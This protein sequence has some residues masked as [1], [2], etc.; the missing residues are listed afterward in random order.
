MVFWEQLRPTYQRMIVK[1]PARLRTSFL[2]RL[3]CGA[4]ELFSEHE[5][6]GCAQQEHG[7]ALK[8]DVLLSLEWQLHGTKLNSGGNPAGL[9]RSDS[10]WRRGVISETA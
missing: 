8:T 6:L 7:V 2:L 1:K 3:S 9:Q 10:L 4:E 5:N